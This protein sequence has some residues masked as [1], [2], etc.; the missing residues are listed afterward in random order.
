[1]VLEIKSWG[2]HAQQYLAKSSLGKGNRGKRG[3][4]TLLH[5]TVTIPGLSMR[6]STQASQ[7]IN[8]L[9]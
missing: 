7:K 6:K 3:K 1:M 5:G 8:R 2:S 9:L 4:H